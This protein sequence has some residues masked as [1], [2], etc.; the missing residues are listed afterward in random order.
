MAGAS[1]GRV[2]RFGRRGYQYSSYGAPEGLSGASQLYKG[3]QALQRGG[4]VM[5]VADGYAGSSPGI[6]LPFYGRNRIFRAGFAELALSAGAAIVP[7]SVSMD[8]TGHV[9][10]RFLPRLE[11]ASS[12]HQ[13]QIESLVLQYVEILRKEWAKNLSSFSWKQLEKFLQLPPAGEG[14]EASIRAWAS[15]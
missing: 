5:I 15:G 6:A 14:E 4:I 13:Q 9:N 3:R 2:Q 1:P 7:A 8:M 12:S 10:V 11:I